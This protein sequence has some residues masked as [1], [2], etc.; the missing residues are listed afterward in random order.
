MRARRNNG[1]TFWAEVSLKSS[2][3]GGDLRI[4][5]VVRDFTER[6]KNEEVI[7]QS[8][9]RFRSIIQYLTDVIWILDRDLNIMYESPSAGRYWDM[10]RVT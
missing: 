6:R 10:I 9:V 5:T 2:E 7:R 1:E 4:I 8:E 3:I